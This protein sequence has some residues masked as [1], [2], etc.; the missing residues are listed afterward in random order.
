MSEIYIEQLE[1]QNEIILENE[2]SAD[3]VESELDRIQKQQRE[4]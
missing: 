1:E 4:W 2:L 3:E